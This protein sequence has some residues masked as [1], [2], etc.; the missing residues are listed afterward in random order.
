MNGSEGVG[1]LTTDMQVSCR[2]GASSGPSL[3]PLLAFS[4]FFASSGP[5]F[6]PLLA[7]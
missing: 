7:P 4:A 5:A 6:G 3:V 2:P 1:V